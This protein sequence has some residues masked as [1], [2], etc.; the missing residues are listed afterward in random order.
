MSK[1]PDAATTKPEPAPAPAPDTVTVALDAPIQRGD[2]SIASVV[3][4]RPRAGELRGL[5]LT[6][7]LQMQVDALLQLLPRIT[8]PTLL[9]HELEAM[10]VADLIQLGSEATSF[11]LTRAQA[12]SLPE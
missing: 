12:A 11:F 4:R 5:N 1:T 9:K 3:L 7:V 8:Q 2:E 10:N 6:Q